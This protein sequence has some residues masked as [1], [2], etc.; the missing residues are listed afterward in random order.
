MESLGEGKT[1]RNGNKVACETNHLSTFAVLSMPVIQ[2]Y[3]TL[4][5]QNSFLIPALVILD[6]CLLIASIAGLFF[7]KHGFNKLTENDFIEVR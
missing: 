7:D 5:F 4:K 2:T 1:V 6:V 3:S